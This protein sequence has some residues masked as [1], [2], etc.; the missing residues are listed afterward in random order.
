MSGC[1][2]VIDDKDLTGQFKL[3]LRDGNKI[4][5]LGLGT[6]L[7]NGDE[8]IS[9]VKLALELGY[10]HI[11]TAEGYNNQKEI[12]LALEGFDRSK[13]FITSK[14]WMGNLHY[15]EVL[16]LC[17]KALQEL[18]TDYL[19]LLLIHWPNKRIPMEETFD[20]FEELV[21]TGKV[22][23]IGVSNFTVNHLKDAMNVEKVPVAVNE[24][25]FHPYLY[26]E[27]LI[28]F[29][30]KNRIITI[31]YSPLARGNCLRDTIIC[32][33][34]KKYNKTAA[35]ICL[36][37]N[38]QKGNVIIP[39]S[40]SKDRLRE[41]MDVFDWELLKVDVESIDVLN[42]NLRYVNPKFNEFD[43]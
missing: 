3:V 11:D 14:I 22:I 5:A 19:D 20:A 42:K 16:R 31:A 38:L 32:E 21:D 8:C 4:P 34:A 43:Y 40:R 25:E 36:R 17:N 24:V 9:A 29:C 26:Q 10:R 2:L 35:Q 6:W 1:N 30:S 13:V 41:N 33:I 28:E 23:S 27:D 37:W 15:S 39:K 18:R 12:G 7:L